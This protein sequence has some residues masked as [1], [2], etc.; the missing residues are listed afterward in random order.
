MISGH[1]PARENL[2]WIECQPPAGS[3]ALHLRLAE[4]AG[5]VLKHSRNGSLS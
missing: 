1:G 4:L 2:C 5:V 3:T